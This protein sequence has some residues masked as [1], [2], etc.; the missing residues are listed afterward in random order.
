M[1]AELEPYETHQY[2]S[3]VKRAPAKFAVQR[4]LSETL[5]VEING[6]CHVNTVTELLT[7]V[8]GRMSLCCRSLAFSTC[9]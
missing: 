7:A 2:S 5:A 3:T 9:P 8:F 4:P 6:C 1:C